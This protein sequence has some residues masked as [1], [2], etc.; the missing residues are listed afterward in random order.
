MNGEPSGWLPLQLPPTELLINFFWLHW[1]Y[2][3]LVWGV[4]ITVVLSIWLR[5]LGV[6]SV[7]FCWMVWAIMGQAAGAYV[8]P[9]CWGR[10]V[11]VGRRG[12]LASAAGT[13]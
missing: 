13:T 4:M 10:A 11:P 2:L 1:I 8:G 7:A 9:T 5:V 6:P 12:D 3:G